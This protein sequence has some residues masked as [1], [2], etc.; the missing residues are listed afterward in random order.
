MTLFGLFQVVVEEHIAAAVEVGAVFE[1]LVG[2]FVQEIDLQSV[3]VVF[4]GDF[5]LLWQF[6]ELVFVEQFAFGL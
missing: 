4:Q 1:E 6:V 5:I 2:E 3:V